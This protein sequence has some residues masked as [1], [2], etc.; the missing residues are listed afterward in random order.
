[1]HQ[2]ERL[3]D[4]SFL[5][6][7]ITLR[8]VS[9]ALRPAATDTPSRIPPTSLV[10]KLLSQPPWFAMLTGITFEVVTL[11]A[12]LAVVH[13]VVSTFIARRLIRNEQA[14]V[15]AQNN[16]ISGNFVR[17]VASDQLRKAS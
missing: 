17:N 15:E 9:S 12:V 2:P 1:M 16:V 7:G 14:L 13:A 5:P 4:N 8:D 11:L 3:S 6:A 10:C